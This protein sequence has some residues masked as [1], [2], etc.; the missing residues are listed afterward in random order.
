M[1]K[2]KV[3]DAMCGAGKTSW[4][5]Q[6]INGNPD[7]TFVYCTPFLDE[8]TRI[9]ESCGHFQRF[10]EPR[11]NGGSKIDDFNRLLAK[12][13]DIAVTH[14]T[15]LNATSQTM[16]LIQDGGYT[17]ILDEVLDVVTDFNTAQSVV[18]QEGQRVKKGDIDFL[19]ENKNIVIDEK[20]R[21]H[22]KSG[23]F[24]NFKYSEVERFAKLGRLYCMDNKLLLT[25]YPP[26][27]FQYFDNVYVMTYLFGG[28]TLKNYF[29]M[30]NIPY[31][32]CSVCHSEDGYKLTDWTVEAELE[33]R[34]KYKN[35]IH[36]IENERMNGEYSRKG[37][38]SSIR[39][40]NASNEKLSRLKSHLGNFFRR[41]AKDPING[42]SASATDETIMWTTK[43][44]DNNKIYRKLKG[45]GY[46]SRKYTDTERKALETL[47]GVQRQRYKDT[48]DKKCDCFVPCN[49]RATNI[50]NSRWALA[51]CLNLNMKPEIQKLFA[52]AHVSVNNDLYSLSNL[53]QWIFRS[54]IRNQEP[55]VLYLPSERMRGLLKKWIDGTDDSIKSFVQMGLVQ[56]IEK[57]A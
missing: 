45:E 52:K 4:A 27:V 28:S 7:K 13:C 2:V 14:T 20:N 30:F 17:L 38:I 21:V 31:E 15:F 47:S 32:I 35:L 44:G 39:L 50:Y 49:A 56:K 46:T 6:Y 8:I 43:K 55:I 16:D 10:E 25:I 41:V 5:I 40:Q 48:L 37:E 24:E 23:H 12:G 42:K 29:D 1:E 22:W 33:Q 18:N 19:I 11:H 9:R 26:E 53:L 34:A 3:I 36:I 51:Y 54:R 57:T